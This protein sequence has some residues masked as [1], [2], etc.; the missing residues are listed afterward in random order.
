[1]R[2]LNGSP[3]AAFSHRRGGRIK[4]CDWR[5][6][7]EDMSKS[8]TCRA[9]KQFIDEARQA[10]GIEAIVSSG[11]DVAEQGTLLVYVASLGGEAEEHVYELLGRVLREYPDARLR[12]E[13]DGLAE[14]GISVEHLSEVIPPGACVLS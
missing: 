3:G 12:V 1:V 11:G 4:I 6:A 9:Q 13:V 2:E 10:P 14:L 7:E 5:I 8:E